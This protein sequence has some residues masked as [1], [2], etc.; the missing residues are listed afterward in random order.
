KGFGMLI[1]PFPQ[2]LQPYQSETGSNAKGPID[3]IR[4]LINWI[5]HFSGKTF[6][7]LSCG[8]IASFFPPGHNKRQL[9]KRPTN[10]SKK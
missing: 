3:K 6:D 8:G 1:M 5:G 4:G 10:S 7:S 9:H 2:F